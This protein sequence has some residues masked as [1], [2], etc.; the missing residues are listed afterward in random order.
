MAEGAHHHHGPVEYRYCPRCGGELQHRS[1]KPSEPKRLVCR[2]CC[3]IFYLDPK[4]I[5]GTLFTIDGGVVLLKRGIEP[6]LGKWS[7]PGGYVDRGE[8]VQEAAIRETKEEV[9]LDVRL[10]SLLGVYSYSRSPNVVVVYR[11]EVMSGELKAGDEA[12]EAREFSFHEI[13]WDE[14]AF[15]ST[16]DALQDFI[17]L[18]PQ[19]KGA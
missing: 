16:K 5:S 12:T 15:V 13:P 7:F 8:S 18:H 19:R 11:A 2:S 1:L 9:H 17:R 14:L 3:F 4:V 6:A 10:T